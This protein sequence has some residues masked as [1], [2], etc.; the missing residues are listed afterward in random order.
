[1]SEWIKE[2]F[3]AIF[4]T[5]SSLAT[6][7]ISMIPIVELRGAIPF[8]SATSF[9]GEHALELWE[10]L[11]F[12]LLGSTLVCVILTFLFWPIFKW[13]KQT[14]AF[15]K[16]ALWV[17]NK[18][19][20]KAE[21]INNKTENEKDAKKIKWLKIIG[22][23]GFVAIPLPL[24][25]VWT[26]TCLALFI[27]LNKK[28]TMSTVVLGNI[29]AGLLM[30][31][32]SYFFADNTMIVF[33]AF[34]ILV[35]VFILFALIKKLI[36]KIKNKNKTQNDEPVTDT[37]KEVEEKSEEDKTSE[38]E[39]ELNEANVKSTEDENASNEENEKEND[40]KKDGE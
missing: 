8:G 14:K 10:S 22:I 27:G 20:N 28:E 21:N 33:Y 7:I 40:N 29:V 5:N 16:L 1:M 34:F 12:S 24:T 30:T 3:V 38:V 23:F 25:G 37:I 26:G 17:E 6:I 13:L 11:L 35:G 39:L 4:G 18:L 15:K 9:W 2:L 19:N 32:I 31:L 36:N